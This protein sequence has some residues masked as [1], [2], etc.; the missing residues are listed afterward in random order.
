MNVR[1]AWGH[2]FRAHRKSWD[3]TQGD[4]A[5]MVGASQASVTAWERGTRTPD[6]EML[7]KLVRALDIDPRLLFQ[8]EAEI[9]DVA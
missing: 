7:V 6:P 3:L 2:V 4:V 5:R 8:V 9:A 1:V